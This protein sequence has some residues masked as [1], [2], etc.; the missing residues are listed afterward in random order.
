MRSSRRCVLLLLAWQ[1]FLLTGCHALGDGRGTLGIFGDRDPRVLYSVDTDRRLVALTIDDGP[2]AQSTAE[3][4]SVLADHDARAT[5]FLISSRIPG[6]EAVVDAI[7]AGGHELGNHHQ[8]DTPSIELSQEEFEEQLLAAQQALSVWQTPRWFRPAS[9][10]YHDWMLDLLEEHDYR[11]ALGSVYPLDAQIPL[12]RLASW[13]IGRG[14]RAGS[15]IILHDGEGRGERSAR[16]LERILPQLAARG[17]EVVT[18]TELL[19]RS[20]SPSGERSVDSV[21]KPEA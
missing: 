8:R 20:A 14:V 1:S 10:W 18:L 15:I 17:L 13:W 11:C 21:G 5:F 4:L 12:E 19:E 3:I 7:V 6:N 16:V 9:G 2:D